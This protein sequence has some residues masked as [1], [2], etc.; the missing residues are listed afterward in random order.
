MEISDDKTE[1][2][3]WVAK[4]GVLEAVVRP[5]DLSHYIIARQLASNKQWIALKMKD[6]ENNDMPYPEYFEFTDSAKTLLDKVSDELFVGGERK[7][8]N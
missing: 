3:G 6:I 4:D 8:D 7:N 5:R 1:V 2:T